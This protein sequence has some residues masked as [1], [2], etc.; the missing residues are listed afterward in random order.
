MI[1]VPAVV[2]F[3]SA[4]SGTGGLAGFAHFEKSTTAVHEVWFST[5]VSDQG[6]APRHNWMNGRCHHTMPA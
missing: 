5:A 3:T 4:R 2:R 6:F 1:W